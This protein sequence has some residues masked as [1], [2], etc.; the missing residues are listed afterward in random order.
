MPP[1]PAPRPQELR[2]V[3]TIKTFQALPPPEGGAKPPILAYFGQ[4]LG[5]RDGL[6]HDEGLALARPVAE[7]GQIEL[8]SR[9][10]S[11]KKL[12]PSEELGDIIR[13][14]DAAAAVKVYQAVAEASMPAEAKAR[15]AQQAAEE[16]A[17]ATAARAAKETGRA[18]KARAK[19]SRAQ[20]ALDALTAGGGGEGAVAA[21][22]E[23]AKAADAAVADAAK[24]ARAAAAK[25]KE[26]KEAA[27]AAK[28]EAE[29]GAT[30]AAEAKANAEADAAAVPATAEQ[31]EQAAA[32]VPALEEAAAAAEE[33]ASEFESTPEE[34]A[35][36]QAA[37]EAAQKARDLAASTKATAAMAVLAAEASAKAAVQAEAAVAA[38]AAAAEAA[39]ATAA[40]T[41]EAAAAAAKAMEAKTEQAAAAAAGVDAAKAAVADLSTSSEAAAKEAAE[42]A[43]EASAAEAKAAEAEGAAAKD[44]AAV[45]EAKATVAR[46]VSARASAPTK[47]MLCY[48]E[49]GDIDEVMHLHQEQTPPALPDWLE[50]LAGIGRAR[51]GGPKAVAFLERLRALP[52]PPPPPDP[53]DALAVAAAS[54]GP[55]PPP[56]APATGPVA[57]AL[58]ECGC[59]QEA[60]Q[61]ALGDAAAIDAALQTRLLLGSL[62]ANA[63]VGEALLEAG[64]FK[65]FD[66]RAVA[67]RCE[68]LGGP[69]LACALRLYSALEDLSRVL[70]LEPV[71]AEAV[72]ARV[73]VMPPADGLAVVAALLKSDTPRSRAK[74]QLAAQRHAARLGH[75]ALVAAFAVH[76]ESLL[77]YLG[78]QMVA[79]HEEA[80][81]SGVQRVTLEYLRAAREMGMGDEVERLTRDPKAKYEPRAVL[82]LL[83]EAPPHATPEEEAA[84]A[85]AY[86]PRPLINVCDR[87][88]LVAELTQELLRRRMLGHLK[89]YLQHVN[90][91]KAP[92]VVAALLDAGCEPP[93]AAEMLAKLDAK[94]LAQDATFCERLVAACEQRKQLGLLRPW[95]EARQAE[96]LPEGGPDAEVV[97]GALE[98]IEK[99][100][101]AWW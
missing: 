8:L 83:T 89:L 3:E 62:E 64:S 88:E 26:A 90:P 35:A 45:E 92:Q 34:V 18:E 5:R 15:E 98:R 38:V 12:Q 36:A 54:L 55:P 99:A 100:A 71:D 53:N 87:Y 22:R 52:P 82:A 16:K 50:V 96:G 97:K 23:A 57:A 65:D 47:V 91:C 63:A 1:R 30:N 28:A 27:A 60:T 75:E 51:G 31:A 69:L 17:S 84:A 42:A 81:E 58:L 4:L 33:V 59:V 10:I 20:A 37:T 7:Q 40:A 9:W 13:E 72:S 93:R 49:Q 61:V 73:G 77:R 94:V 44:A 41:A 68:A 14:K 29:R 85:K 74:A 76:K 66:R 19:A 101:K 78:S 79:R 11:D 24:A 43:E 21:A 6:K 32:A 56:P 39:A 67:A 2:T 86:D 95:L 25:A 48:A 46:E 70:C 80:D